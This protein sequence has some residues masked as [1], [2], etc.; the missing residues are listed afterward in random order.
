MLKLVKEHHLF[1]EAVCIEMGFV[2]FFHQI[3]YLL[4]SGSFQTFSHE[5]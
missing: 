4:A 5:P 2:K 1:A 3:F